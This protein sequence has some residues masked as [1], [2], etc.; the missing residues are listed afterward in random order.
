MYYPQTPFFTSWVFCCWCLSF[1]PPYFHWLP[2]VYC[3]VQS[4]FWSCSSVAPVLL[5]PVDFEFNLVWS[6][7]L[8]CLLVLSYISVLRFILLFPL[9]V[10]LGSVCSLFVCHSLL[11]LPR[12]VCLCARGEGENWGFEK[13]IEDLKFRGE[14]RLVVPYGRFDLR[15]FL[16]YGTFTYGIS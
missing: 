3:L 7:V 12:L 8:H 1:F 13:G 14:Q 15:D 2:L 16:T 4:S 9:F 6:C 10:L 11:C 5:C